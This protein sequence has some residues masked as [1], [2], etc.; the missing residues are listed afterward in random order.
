MIFSA[1]FFQIHFIDSIV[2]LSPSFA[3][4]ISKSTQRESI[5]IAT[6]PQ[7]QDIFINSENNFFSVLFVK[8]KRFSEFS[9]L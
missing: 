8:A 6:F 1:I 9:V 7:I 4:E 3:E 5:C 2:L